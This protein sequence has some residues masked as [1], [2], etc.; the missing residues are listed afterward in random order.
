MKEKWKTIRN[1]KDVKDD[2]YQV[3]NYGNVRHKS[4]KKEI[5]KKIANKKKHPYYAVSLSVYSSNEKQWILVHQLV[6][7]FFCKIPK[8]Y[9]NT[10]D[11]VPD[12]IDNDGLNNFYKN[13]EWKTRGENV[14]SAFQKGFCDNSCDKN[15]GAVIN[16]ET[17][18]RICELMERGYDYDS[19]IDAM[20]LP[21]IKSYRTLLVRIKN[22][23]AWTAISKNF[24]IPSSPVV[25]KQNKKTLEM[26]PEIINL[27]NSGKSNSEIVSILWP[28]TDKRDSK[29]ETLR[30]IRNRE[31]YTDFLGD[32]RA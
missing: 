31:I 12:H 29:M 17:A 18:T 22:G 19:I 15:K 3:S 9:E 26:L 8:R 21:D 4:T 10:D 11:L 32:L 6:A 5:H 13:L 2:I 30:R 14:S 27:M 24:N 23:Y 16:N 28:N 25:S 1:F 7:T 20:G